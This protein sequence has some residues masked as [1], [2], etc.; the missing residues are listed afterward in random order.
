MRHEMCTGSPPLR[1]EINTSTVP[2]S[3]RDLRVVTLLFSALSA[4]IQSCTILFPGSSLLLSVSLLVP[5]R[6]WFATRHDDTRWIFVYDAVQRTHTRFASVEYCKR[7]CMEVVG[8]LILR[9]TSTVCF[10]TRR[11]DRRWMQWKAVVKESVHSA[12]PTEMGNRFRSDRNK[13]RRRFVRVWYG[14]GRGR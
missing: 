5:Y 14:R 2:V 6:A 7:S 8:N 12:V 3:R 11:D 10:A 13:Q 9:S 4:A 1:T